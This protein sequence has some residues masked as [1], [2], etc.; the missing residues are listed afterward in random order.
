MGA[1]EM[2][3]AAARGEGALLRGVKV[4]A[5]AELELGTS[6]FLLRSSHPRNPQLHFVFMSTYSGRIKSS[7]ENI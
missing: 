1:S 7:Y 6:G 3:D 5:Q 4:P 2:E